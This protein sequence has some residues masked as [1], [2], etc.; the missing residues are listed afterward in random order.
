MFRYI[1]QNFQQLSIISEEEHTF[2]RLKRLKRKK[3]RLCSL[4]LWIRSRCTVAI[5][6]LKQNVHPAKDEA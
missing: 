5:K 1:S 6:N 4:N 2:R 3:K